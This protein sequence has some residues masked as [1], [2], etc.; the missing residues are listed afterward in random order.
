MRAL[1][2]LAVAYLIGFSAYGD[3]LDELVHS[4]EDV[5]TPSEVLDMLEND[6]DLELRTEDQG[7]YGVAT[8]AGIDFGTIVNLGKSIWTVIEKNAP[9]AKTDYDFANALPAG[10]KSASALAGFSDIQHK[11]IRLYGENGFGMKVYDVTYTLVSQYGGSYRGRG[12][13]LSTVAVI[14][15]RVSVLVGY[16][17]DLKVVN[18]AV[19]NVGTEKDPVG[20]VALNVGL[21]IDSPLKTILKTV[22]YQFRGDTK[23]I[24]E[25]L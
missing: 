1:V 16:K 5:E 9:V 23:E 14:P 12:K 8:A 2:C 19:V 13:Y 7:C 6:A 21:K 10:V 11:S 15:S 18:A 4:S 20:S 22:I 24:Q 25:T 3:D 17:L